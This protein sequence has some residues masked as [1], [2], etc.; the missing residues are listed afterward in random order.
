MEVR[1]FFTGQQVEDA[2]R[3]AQRL[4]EQMSKD[5]DEAIVIQSTDTEKT[6]SRIDLDANHV[7]TGMGPVEKDGTRIVS[8]SLIL[9]DEDAPMPA[10]IM[11]SQKTIDEAGVLADD[12]EPAKPKPTFWPN[13]GAIDGDGKSDADEA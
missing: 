4:V 8:I 12:S 10:I 9:K 7:I 6:I 2:V 5:G 11:V 13:I 1:R 3:E